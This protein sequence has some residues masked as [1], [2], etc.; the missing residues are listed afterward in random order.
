[1]M[2][3]Y[4]KFPTAFRQPG[5]FFS[6]P[7]LSI[8]C[9][10]QATYLCDA[11]ERGKTITDRQTDRQTEKWAGKQRTDRNKLFTGKTILV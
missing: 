4:A 1:M 9:A 6:S 10:E 2:S 5:F 8:L 7:P 11:S 3:Y